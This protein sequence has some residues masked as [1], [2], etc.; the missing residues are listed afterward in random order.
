MRYSYLHIV[1]TN[2]NI[3]LDKSI[4]DET[5]TVQSK[6]KNNGKWRDS[7][8][9]LDFQ[10]YSLTI[11]CSLLPRLRWQEENCWKQPKR[12]RLRYHK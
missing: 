7:Q 6:H 4:L 10:K 2:T 8:N 9:I 3:F 1:L 5:L 12:L 11:R